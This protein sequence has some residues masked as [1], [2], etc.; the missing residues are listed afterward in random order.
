M[1]PTATVSV[2]DSAVLKPGSLILITGVLGYIGAHLADQLLLRGYKVRGVV[3]KPADWLLEIF[4]S[5]YGKATL[6]TWFLADLTDEEGLSKAMQA[7][8]V[9]FSPDPNV[10]IPIAVN[11][12]TTALKAAAKASSVQRFV[13]TSSSAAASVCVPNTPRTITASSWADGSIEQARQPGPYTPDRGMSTY[14]AS[15][16]LAEQ[17]IWNWA[18]ENK[19]RD[20]VVNTVLPDFNLG[21]PI[22]PEHQGWPSSRIFGYAEPK[23]ANGILRRYKELYPNREFADEDPEE[24]EDLGVKTG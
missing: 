11:L 24:G 5:K 7:S 18:K 17:A 21:L 22:S 19:S 12:A 16:A 6:E 3:R 20:L 23:N 4:D 9:S 10:V 13:L 2:P 15:K 14:G 8:D 1:S